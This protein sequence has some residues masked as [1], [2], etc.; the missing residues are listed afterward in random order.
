MA[1]KSY[2]TNTNFDILHFVGKDAYT[3]D[4]KYVLYVAQRNVL[5]ENYTR[6]LIAQKRKQ[7]RI[8]DLKRTVEQ[9]SYAVGT[10]GRAFDASLEIEE[11][12]ASDENDR[13]N[14]EG[15][16]A[17]I[18]FYDK[19][20]AQL[21]PMCKYIHLGLIAQQEAVQEEEWLLEFVERAR[22]YIQSVG[23]VPADQLSAMKAHPRF[24]ESILPE[25]KMLMANR[26]DL[27]EY[28]E[29]PGDSTQPLA[30][31]N[32]DTGG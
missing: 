13:L 12:E 16:R 28:K 17:E 5:K 1:F 2:R 32:K 25:I 30:L 18:E 3:P 10:T 21:E 8:Q 14:L 19:I 15:G 11:L 24:K 22:N 23:H 7:A 31:S 4:G 6:F 20:I 29:N 9:G 27:I 26:Q